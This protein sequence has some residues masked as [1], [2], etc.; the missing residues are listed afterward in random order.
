MN[1]R[2]LLTFSFPV[3]PV[4]YSVK[5]S[6]SFLTFPIFYSRQP[7]LGGRAKLKVLVALAAAEFGVKD[8]CYLVHRYNLSINLRNLK[9]GSA[10]RNSMNEQSDID[11]VVEC[12]W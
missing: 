2:E 9:F 10:D 4:T 6:R 12:N 1:V 5:M 11:V 3:P 8:I 7:G